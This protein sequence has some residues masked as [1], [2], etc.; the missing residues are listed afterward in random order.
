MNDFAQLELKLVLVITYL[1]GRFRI[2][3]PSALENFE[4]AQIKR[5]QFQNL[6]K[7]RG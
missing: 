1:G 6:Q 3:R 4:F 7:S 2:N 5:G